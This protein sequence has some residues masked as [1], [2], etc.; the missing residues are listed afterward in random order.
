VTTARQLTL[1]CFRSWWHYRILT[2]NQHS[3]H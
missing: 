3:R 1:T 2:D